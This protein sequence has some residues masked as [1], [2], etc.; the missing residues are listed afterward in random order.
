MAV[1]DENQINVNLINE[2]FPKVASAII[3][4]ANDGKATMSAETMKEKYPEI[5]ASF[6][7]EGKTA[8]IDIGKIEGAKAESAR[9]ASIDAVSVAGYEDV[10]A[11]AKA[12][13]KSTAQDVKL[14]I[15]DKM[16][17]STKNASALRS[18]DGTNLAAQVAELTTTTDTNSD[19]L[20]E[21]EAS[22]RM[23]KAAKVARGEK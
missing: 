16:Q 17:E 18:E 13:G 15:F 11:A 8:G 22:E 14:A 10:V 23:A 5:V 21:K 1:Y 7:E 3:A 20:A 9:V 4:Q 2:K 12:D 6:I 19:E